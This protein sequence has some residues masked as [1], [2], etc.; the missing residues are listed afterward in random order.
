[1]ESVPYQKKKLDEAEATEDEINEALYE[2]DYCKLTKTKLR[3]KC[4]VFPIGC[5][6]ASI[7]Y[8]KLKLVQ[9]VGDTFG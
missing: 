7:V 5:D 2:D 1:M 3:I 4:Y 6:K 8:W 9:F